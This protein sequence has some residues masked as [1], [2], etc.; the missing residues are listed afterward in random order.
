MESARNAKKNIVMPSE[1]TAPG[2][3]TLE[4]RRAAPHNNSPMVIMICKIKG[5]LFVLDASGSKL[6]AFG[7]AKIK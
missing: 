5:E 7:T 1:H 4:L 2:L 3:S 6:K